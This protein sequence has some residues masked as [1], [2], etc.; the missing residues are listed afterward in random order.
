[1]KVSVIIEAVERTITID[2]NRKTT[3]VYWILCIRLIH[4]SLVTAAASLFSSGIF[5]IDKEI[6]TKL[7]IYFGCYILFARNSPVPSQCTSSLDGF[8]SWAEIQ[9]FR[10]PSLR[11]TDAVILKRLPMGTGFFRDVLIC[12]VN[13][14]HFFRLPEEQNPI[15]PIYNIIRK[16]YWF[17]YK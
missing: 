10:S 15:Q 11:W 5:S 4:W 7:Q 3:S 1:M 16:I 8:V 12:T 9:S 6:N 13:P 2:R 14:L 17:R